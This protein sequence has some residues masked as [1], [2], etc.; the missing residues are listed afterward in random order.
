MCVKLKVGFRI[1]YIFLYCINFLF[2][3]HLFCC[4]FITF[5]FGF[6][7]L[8]FLLSSHICSFS[9][10]SCPYFFLVLVLV[11]SCCFSSCL[12]ISFQLSFPSSFLTSSMFLKK[13]S[14]LFPYLHSTTSLFSFSI[15]CTTTKIPSF[16][17]LSFFLHPYSSPIFSSTL[18][19]LPSIS[20]H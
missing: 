11:L 3:L 13:N 5:F 10:F 16:L 6:V 9:H 20:S 1:C 2:L 7:L 14:L 12:T 8:V 15:P 4:P 19:V 18:Y 17:S